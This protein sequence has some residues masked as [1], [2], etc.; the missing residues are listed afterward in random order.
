MWVHV[1]ER[2]T[3]HPNGHEG[4]EIKWSPVNKDPENFGPIWEKMRNVY[5]YEGGKSRS[6]IPTVGSLPLV[7]LRIMAVTVISGSLDCPG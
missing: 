5:F 3:H 7:S 4:G 2:A 6:P 1:D